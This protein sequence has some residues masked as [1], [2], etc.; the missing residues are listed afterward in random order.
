MPPMPGMGAP[1]PVMAVQQP[2]PQASPG[3]VGGIQI[4]IAHIMQQVIF[5]LD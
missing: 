3:I 1:Q 4:D 5:L 2:V